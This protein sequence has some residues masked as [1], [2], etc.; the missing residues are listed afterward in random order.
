MYKHRFAPKF[1][2]FLKKNFAFSLYSNILYSYVFGHV[3]HMLYY[4]L[5]CFCYKIPPKRRKAEGKFA[6]SGSHFQKDT[7]PHGGK[8][9]AVVAGL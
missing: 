6:Y 3:M 1:V 4:F 9:M 2:S 8:S 5:F 7:V